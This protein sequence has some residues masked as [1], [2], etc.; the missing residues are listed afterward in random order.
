MLLSLRSLAPMDRVAF[1]TGA[2]YSPRGQRIGI[3]LRDVPQVHLQ[4]CCL[5]DFDPGSL[6][7]SRCA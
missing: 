6:G 1:N 3:W 2:Y 4:L 5:V 7:I